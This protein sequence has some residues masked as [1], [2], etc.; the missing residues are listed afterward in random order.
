[1][2]EPESSKTALGVAVL[3]AVHQLIDTT[4]RILDDP[5]ILQILGPAVLDG[6]RAD[7]ARYQ[8]PRSLGL[9]S[10]VVIRSRY[11]ED[12]LAQA[13]LHGIR[14]ILILGAGFDT[15]PYRQPVWA[16]C[17]RI[18]EVDH[19]ATQRDKLAR[20]QAAAIVIPPNVEFIPVDFETTSLADGLKASH[21]DFTQP[22][23]VS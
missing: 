18:F 12:R 3:R 19:P 4:P 14:Q 6:I 16:K 7:P 22:A 9:R 8:T 21:F 11:A 15:F 13:F 2:T 20:L 10:H 23:F 17:L 5:V 1:M